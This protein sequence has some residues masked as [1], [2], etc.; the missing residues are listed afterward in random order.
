MKLGSDLISLDKSKRM[1]KQREL[2]LNAVIGRHDHPT[3]K[4]IFI[5]LSE[6]K[7]GLATVYR[8]LSSMVDE[9]ILLSF[10]HNGQIRFDPLTS[11]HAHIIC[12]KCNMIWDVNMPEGIEHLE[13]S[14]GQVMINGVDLT[15]KGICGD[16]R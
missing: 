16:C 11:N 7:I 10:E 3:A 5:Q 6:H 1:T 8:Q 15:W 14:T 9:G 4:D 2:V 13:P 12:S